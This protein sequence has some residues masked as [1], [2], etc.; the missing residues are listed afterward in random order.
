[1]STDFVEQADEITIAIRDHVFDADDFFDWVLGRMRQQPVLMAQVVFKL[2][3]WAVMDPQARV[4]AE[5]QVMRDR[6]QA[7]AIPVPCGIC[8]G[9]MVARQYRQPHLLVA[10][11]KGL[12]QSC[13]QI[14][15][16]A[17]RVNETADV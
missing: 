2:A 7:G 12:C 5:C 10:N 8:G 13:Y 17:G 15:W 6:N 14:A 11:A 1:M 4:E 9:L 3:Q 16:Q